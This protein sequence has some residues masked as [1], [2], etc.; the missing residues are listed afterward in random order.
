M[1]IGG[2]GSKFA[3][4]FK[5]VVNISNIEVKF[6]EPIKQSPIST[7]DESTIHHDVR[8]IEILKHKQV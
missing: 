1:K 7:N 2:G 8:A 5:K 4:T 3:L 6:W